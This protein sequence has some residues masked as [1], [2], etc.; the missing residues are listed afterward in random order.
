[1]LHLSRVILR[2]VDAL[3]DHLAR[4]ERVIVTLE[5]LKGYTVLESLWAKLCL[6]SGMLSNTLLTYWRS[7]PPLRHISVSPNLFLL[8]VRGWKSMRQSCPPRGDNE[9]WRLI[10][11][12]I[13]LEATCLLSGE[14][15]RRH[16]GQSCKPTE[17]HLWFIFYLLG[18][19]G[20]VNGW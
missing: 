10:A 4:A 12:S 1:M 11:P 18:A 16:T 3:W 20:S 2:S 8:V 7:S 6:V 5:M 14:L 19:V 9:R 17:V 13:F 15:N